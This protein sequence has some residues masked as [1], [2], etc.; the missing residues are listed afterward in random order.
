MHSTFNVK[1][2]LTKTFVNI[3]NEISR[4]NLNSTFITLTNEIHPF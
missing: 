3:F 4:P 1:A 2:P